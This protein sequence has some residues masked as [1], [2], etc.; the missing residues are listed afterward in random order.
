[1]EN[2]KTRGRDYEQDIKPEYLIEIN[3]SYLNFIKS[4]NKLKV[5]IID[6]SEKDFVNNRRDYL[7][8]LEEIGKAH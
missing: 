4:Q 2:I 6:I 7:D 1:L 8:L 5:Q 3:K